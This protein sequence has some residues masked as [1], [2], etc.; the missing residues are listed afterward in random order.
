[1]QTSWECFRDA[2]VILA[3]GGPVKQRLTDAFQCQLR[4]IDPESLPRDLRGP[5][6]TLHA[7]LQSGQRIGTL[8]AIS[9]SVR[10]MSEAEAARHAQSIVL[11]F[12]GLQEPAT[13]NRPAVLRAVPNTVDDE[14][15]AFL[16]R[17]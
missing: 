12:A 4:D 3:G 8:D 11:M 16:N 5:F 15:P 6:C 10:K 7:A 9:A 14:I 13:A 1:M 2:V 17:A